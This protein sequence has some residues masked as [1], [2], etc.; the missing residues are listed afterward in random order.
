M[1]L[2]SMAIAGKH[3]RNSV[4]EKLLRFLWVGDLNEAKNYLDSLSPSYVKSQ[5]WLYE[6]IAYL[7]RKE[8]CIPCYAVRAKLGLRISSNPVE[9]ANDILVAQ[10][11]KHNGM[12]WSPKGS[13]ALASIEIIYRNNQEDLW[14][15]ERQL[16]GFLSSCSFEVQCA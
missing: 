2:L 8:D 16:P 11:Q 14:F 4:L 6:T 13:G 12:A 3:K 15:K 7:K 1:E 10:R 5:K 9:K